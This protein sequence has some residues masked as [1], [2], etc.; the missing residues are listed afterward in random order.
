MRVAGLRSVL[1]SARSGRRLMG[2]KKDS[3]AEAPTIPLHEDH[4]SLPW[5]RKTDE[6]IVQEVLRGELSSTALEKELKDFKRAV[7]AFLLF[8]SLS[9]SLGSHT[10]RAGVDSAPSGRGKGKGV[11]A[12]KPRDSDGRAVGRA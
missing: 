10:I 5:I 11:A 12:R 9:L 6:Q 7:G 4:D 2:S 3:E 1:N 8:F